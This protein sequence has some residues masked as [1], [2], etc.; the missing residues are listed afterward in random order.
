MNMKSVYRWASGLC[1][2]AALTLALDAS[3]VE[4]KYTPPKD[5]RTDIEVVL[6]VVKKDGIYDF[7]LPNSREIMIERRHVSEGFDKLIIKGV[8]TK[9]HGFY[10]GEVDPKTKCFSGECEEF[11]IYPKSNIFEPMKPLTDSNSPNGLRS[12][13]EEE[14]EEVKAEYREAFSDITKNIKRNI[15]IERRLRED[16]LRTGKVG[17]SHR[18]PLFNYSWV[19]SWVH[20]LFSR[21]VVDSM[22]KEYDIGNREVMVVVG[23]PSGKYNRSFLVGGAQDGEHIKYGPF[24]QADIC[25]R[26]GDGHF[27]QVMID[28]RGLIALDE[29]APL[30]GMEDE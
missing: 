10:S 16:V 17:S 28:D 30:I 3:C 29:L 4:D 20:P 1:A 25:D 18:E 21:T 27:E 22:E 8:D 12:L 23:S 13:T 19:P 2:A 7:Y 9:L 26:E 14:I 15:E 11:R 6:D 5:T 24:I